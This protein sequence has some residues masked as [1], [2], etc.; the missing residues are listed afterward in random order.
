MGNKKNPNYAHPA[1]EAYRD[2]TH[3]RVHHDWVD[4]VV[5]TV[6]DD[7]M[8]IARWR[9]TVRTYVGSGWNPKNIANMLRMFRQ[10][11]TPGVKPRE[12]TPQD[13]LR[14]WEERGGSW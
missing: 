13:A 4:E 14:E 5:D 1:A 3:Y 12:Q 11:E 8:E 9:S 10:G 6:G 7:V 2:V